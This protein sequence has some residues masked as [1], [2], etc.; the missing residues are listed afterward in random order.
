MDKQRCAHGEK[1]PSQKAA[2]MSPLI[3]INDSHDQASGAV[4]I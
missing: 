4:Y 1:T 3:E 2:L